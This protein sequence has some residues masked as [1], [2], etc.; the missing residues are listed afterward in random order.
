MIAGH[1]VSPPVTLNPLLWLFCHIMYSELRYRL[2]ISFTRAL[3]FFLYVLP[4]R[5]VYLFTLVCGRQA[6]RYH[7]ANE[8][9]A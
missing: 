7:R 1:S 4:T 5:W 8:A 3:H 2:S 9:R 6:T